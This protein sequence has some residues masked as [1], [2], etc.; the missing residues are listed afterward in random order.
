QDNV[1]ICTGAKFAL[2]LAFLT[3]M[4]P[5]DELL[6][7]A[8]YWVSYTEQAKLAGGTI[9]VIETNWD[10]N[11][12][13]TPEL[14]EKSITP[15][16]KVFLLCSPSNP[17]GTSYR[18]EEIR[19]LTEVIAKHPDIYV[20]SDEVYERLSYADYSFQS[21][22]SA[23]P[24]IADRVITINGVSKSYAMTGWRIGYAVAEKSIIKAM[25]KL[26]GQMTSNITAS[27]MPALVEALTGPQ[28][29]VTSMVKE[30]AKRA[31]HIYER[32][33]KIPHI[34]CPRPTGAFY[35]FPDISYYFGKTDPSGRVL[36]DANILAESILEQVKVAVVS[37][38][39]FGSPNNI[40]IS[41][42]TSM[43]LID[44]GLDRLEDYFESL[45]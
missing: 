6:I 44:K 8:P 22:A 1:I 42:A 14:L 28:D 15:K 26:Q 45:R 36:T 12:K 20:I 11:F 23:N 18:P 17:A 39:D 19:A 24:E 29:S 40:R 9:K 2:Y 16:T 21:F 37:G 3:L 30:F 43:E 35:I 4:N 31:E 27:N 7:P 5:G 10:N 32:I 38:V 41:F 13:V 25:A 33:K 34:E